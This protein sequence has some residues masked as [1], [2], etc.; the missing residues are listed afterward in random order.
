MG[1]IHIWVGNF[2]SEAAFE[3]YFSQESYLKAWSI[4]D[5]EPATGKEGDDQEPDPELRCQFCKDIGIDNYNEDFIVLKYDHQLQEIN[6]ILNDIL[7]DT[8]AFL[9]W[10]EERKI[11]NSNV[12]VAYENHDLP[13]KNASQTKEMIYLGEIEGLSDTGDKV[14]LRTHYLW[15]GKK[16]IPSGIL[17]SL[18]GGKELLKD[19]IAEILGVDKNIIE[20]VNY[21]YTKNK[22]KV[23]EIII[24]H[25]EDYNI[26]EQMILKAEELGVN[27]TTN[28]MLDLL[29]HEGFNL[30]IDDKTGLYYVGGFSE[31]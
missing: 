1:K 29:S 13:Q 3:E 19:K 4:Y 20:E 30:D 27:S 12:M 2:E 10:Y 21:Y 8:A 9:K 7:G 5:H 14:S 15:L 26:A 24:T 25:V 6:M 16:E 17:N 11:E 31:E 22:E 28:L 23:D 18:A